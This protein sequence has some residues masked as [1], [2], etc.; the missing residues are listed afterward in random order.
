MTQ[1]VRWRALAKIRENS[2]FVVCVMYFGTYSVQGTG[3]SVGVCAR[4]VVEVE[5]EVSAA[6]APRARARPVW[7]SPA[8]FFVCFCLRSPAS[9]S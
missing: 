2:F 6:A 3:Y 7:P 5:V 8:P 1:G 4:S 9:A